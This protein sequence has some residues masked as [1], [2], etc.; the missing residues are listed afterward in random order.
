MKFNEYLDK[1]MKELNCSVKELSD[2]STLSPSVISRYRSGEREPSVDSEQ[3]E[4]LVLGLQALAKEQNNS[5]LLS[6]DIYSVFKNALNQKSLQL[7]SFTKNFALIIETLQISIKDLAQA[8]NFDTSYL[9]RIR[10]GERHPNDLH[11]FIDIFSKFILTNYKDEQSKQLLAKLMSCEA[12]QLVDDDEYITSL[13]NWLYNPVEEDYSEHMQNFLQKLDEFDLNEFIRSI[14][15]DEMKVPSVPFYH[16]P[17]KNYYGIEQMQKGE[18]DFFKATVLSKSQEPIFMCSD[19]PMLDMAEN[20]DFNKKWMFGIAAC[21]KRGLHLNIIHN[22]DR[23]FDEM[24]LGLEAWIPIYMTGQISP[25]HLPNVST[26][27]YHHLNYV[28]GVAALTGECIHDFHKDGKYYLT[29]HKE[30]IAYYQK[31]AQNLLSKA[32]PLMEIYRDDTK[33]DFYKFEEAL[34]KEPRARHNV[35]SSLPL[36]TLPDSLLEQ[37]LAKIPLTD[38]KK[39]EIKEYI[40]RQK[41]LMQQVLIHTKVLDEVPEISKEDFSKYPTHLS[42]SG[43]FLEEEIP[44]TYE[45]YLIHYEASKTYMQ[46]NENYEIKT[47][48]QLA[49]RNIQIQIISG[50]HVIISKEKAPVIHFVIHHPKMVSALEAF[51]P[52]ITE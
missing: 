20:M 12:S 8:T 30:E 5:N 40:T 11:A 9:Y 6:E 23:P 32:K 2:V 36:Y 48:N 45:E 46:D 31:K 26:D 38:N 42:L 13:Q 33:K 41:K 28:S 17:N 15:F 50:K 24:M 14:H 39:R 49:F 52:P 35:L 29:S 47:S 22:I 25:Y 16:A 7:Q 37:L 43:I 3:L 1:Y 18:L 4:K 21:L 10:S 51:M 19:M 34:T 27:I 44:Y